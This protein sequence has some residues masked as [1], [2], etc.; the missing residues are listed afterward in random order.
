MAI[1]VKEPARGVKNRL[2]VE[3]LQG[4]WFTLKKL[5]GWT[6]VTIEYP[7]EKRVV[8]PRFRGKH[9]LTV[10]DN[11]RLRCLACY[12][13]AR[14]CPPKCIRIVAKETDDP[15]EKMPESYE[16]DLL[17]CAFC[18]LCVEAC[19]CGALIMTEDYDFTAFSRE[20]LV[21]NI[22]KLRMDKR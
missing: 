5:L 4:M 13:C 16:I 22:E 21:M 17:R 18:G 3:L 7:E 9:A 14:V 12:C 15:M 6:D 1:R 19:P 20:E 11:G 10:D 8:Y 2:Y